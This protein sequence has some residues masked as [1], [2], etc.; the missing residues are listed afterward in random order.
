MIDTEAANLKSFEKLLNSSTKGP[1]ISNCT[2]YNDKYDFMYFLT[3]LRF[4]IGTVK[5]STQNTIFAIKSCAKYS[6]FS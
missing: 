1:F 4:Q 6:H 3:R 5:S 2:L